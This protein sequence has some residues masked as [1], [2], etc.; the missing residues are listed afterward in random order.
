VLVVPTRI[1]RIGIV[2]AFAGLAVLGA[3]LFHWN[4]TTLSRGLLYS[5]NHYEWTIASASS[6]PAL[7]EDEIWDLPAACVKPFYFAQA[8]DFESKLA[9]H[10]ATK[11]PA[12]VLDPPKKKPLFAIDPDLQR[13]SEESNRRF[14]VATRNLDAISQVAKLYGLYDTQEYEAMNK[15]LDENN[16]AVDP[17][18][19]ATRVRLNLLIKRWTSD[20]ADVEG[21]RIARSDILDAVRLPSSISNLGISLAVTGAQS[22]D[23]KFD[24]T[25][26]YLLGL[27]V[28]SS[29]MAKT[30]RL[31]CLEITPVKRV[32]A[33][34]TYG[35][36]I[37]RWPVETPASFWIGIALAVFGLLLGPIVFWVRSAER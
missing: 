30:I 27:T 19:V 17:V 15:A 14:Q 8:R 7:A 32:L 23:D 24:L 36:D 29:A 28:F 21:K 2:I 5:D 25:A 33:N 22:S 31:K 34:T 35:M 6:K 4:Q 12:V 26:K 18:W 11:P 20:A 16:L 3:S 1:A 10:N 13:Q 37:E 9:A